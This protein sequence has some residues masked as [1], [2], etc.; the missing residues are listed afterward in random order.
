MQIFLDKIMRQAQRDPKK[1]V[2]PEGPDERV[3]QAAREVRD[4]GTAF[5]VLLGRTDEIQEKAEKLRIR[6]EDLQIIDP[7][8]SERLTHYAQAFFELRKHKGITE[9]QAKEIIRDVSYFGTMMVRE[10]DADGLVSGATHTTADTLRPAF[11]IV[12]TA[13]EYSIASSYFIILYEDKIYFYADCGLVIDPN[14]EELSEIAVSTVK[15]AGNFGLEP[16]VAML[17]YSTKGSGMGPSVDKV[18]LATEMVKE[19]VPDLLIEGE[20]QIDAALVPEVCKR[21]CADSPLEGNA[22]VLVFPDLNSGNIAYKL[23]ERLVNA[24]ALGPF[25]Q[26]LNKPINDLSRGCSADDI[27]GVTAVTVLEAQNERISP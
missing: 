11:Q 3:L 4:T 1:V 19:R 14:A 15:S 21:K 9:S 26:G 25:I 20:I 24:I 5:P 13:A 8:R 10:G 17:S 18:R 6:I 2:Y 23:T 27:V 12:K 22:N 7:D 16:R